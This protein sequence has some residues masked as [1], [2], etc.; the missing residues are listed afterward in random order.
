MCQ[1]PPASINHCMAAA[2]V[3]GKHPAGSST[4]FITLQLIAGATC[5]GY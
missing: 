4:H 1:Q 5:F 3:P 2:A